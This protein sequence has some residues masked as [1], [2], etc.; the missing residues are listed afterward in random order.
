MKWDLFIHEF[1]SFIGSEKGLS[2]NTIEAYGRDIRRFCEGVK[3]VKEEAIIAYLGDLKEQGYASSSICR[4]L[5]ALRVFF[6]FLKQ[7]GHFEK[8]PTELLESPKMWQLI[9]EVLMSAEV[10]ALLEAPDQDSE[11]GMRDK[12]ILE[13][14]YATGIRA[15]ELCGLNI[16]DV[17]ENMV[18]VMGKR[19]K[20]AGCSDRRRSPGRY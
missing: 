17:G 8:D 16:Y 9:P 20:G 15:S 12:A 5:M 7:E 13:T 4:S 19:G 1:L 6:R 18:R 14:L 3:E 10:E 11:E 2:L